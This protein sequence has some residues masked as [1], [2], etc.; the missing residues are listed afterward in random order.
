MV[1][2][3]SKKVL[4]GIGKCLFFEPILAKCYQN[5]NLKDSWA[6]YDYLYLYLSLVI[7]ANNHGNQQKKGSTQ[8]YKLG[9]SI[10][11]LNFIVSE[12]SLSLEPV[13]G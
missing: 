1:L 9:I 4:S 13:Q 2:G 11:D 7:L 5:Y 12:D 3:D 8:I 6:N 10:S